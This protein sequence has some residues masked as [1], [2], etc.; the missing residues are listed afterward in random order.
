MVC[1]SFQRLQNAKKNFKVSLQKTNKKRKTQELPKTKD[2]KTDTTPTA[3]SVSLYLVL[4]LAVL[5]VNCL[6]TLKR[7]QNHKQKSIRLMALEAP[8]TALNEGPRK[9]PSQR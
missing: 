1:R 3:P 4:T 6:S 5:Y 7:L 9:D 2:Y 8:H